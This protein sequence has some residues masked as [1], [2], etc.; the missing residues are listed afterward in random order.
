MSSTSTIKEA[1]A[2]RALGSSLLSLGFYLLALDRGNVGRADSRA[3]SARCNDSSDC[4][5]PRSLRPLGLFSLYPG[6]TTRGSGMF[7]LLVM[8]SWPAHAHL[9]FLFLPLA[10]N[11][12][13]SSYWNEFL[14]LLLLAHRWH[15]WHG[16]YPSVPLLFASPIFLCIC[17]PCL[18]CHDTLVYELHVFYD[19]GEDGCAEFKNRSKILPN[20]FVN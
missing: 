6:P 18:L 1:R 15:P 11:Y 19:P 14:L 13:T 17:S 9:C 4:K 5:A 10:F 7:P 8:S 3:V 2:L 16:R 12:P 20:A